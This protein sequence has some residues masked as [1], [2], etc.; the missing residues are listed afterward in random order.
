MEAAN[1]I[2]KGMSCQADHCLHNLCPF[3]FISFFSKKDRGKIEGKPSINSKYSSHVEC[4][5]LMV[6]KGIDEM[7]QVV[8]FCQN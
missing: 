3:L 1:L 6:R 5:I 7:R 4:L 8:F 2:R